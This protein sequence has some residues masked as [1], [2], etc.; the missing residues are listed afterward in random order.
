[1]VLYTPMHLILSMGLNETYCLPD[2]PVLRRKALVV[3][4][5]LAW[6]SFDEINR[7][8]IETEVELGKE[9]VLVQLAKGTGGAGNGRKAPGRQ[10]CGI[11][12]K[13]L[14]S[15]EGGNIPRRSTDATIS[16]VM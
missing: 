5:E 15:R 9:H 14:P 13:G 11:A 10:E 1:M 2:D 12:S 3:L 6:A 16:R 4:K 7:A 8:L